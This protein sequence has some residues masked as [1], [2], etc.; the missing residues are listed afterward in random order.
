MRQALPYLFIALTAFCL[1]AFVS[2]LHPE[3]AR[4]WVIKI[5]VFNISPAARAEQY[6]QQMI[7]A[8]PTDEYWKTEALLRGQVF[9]GATPE[10]TLLALGQP[11]EHFDLEVPGYESVTI[12]IYL[13]EGSNRYTM[14]QFL[15][16]QLDV[17]Q[18]IAAPEVERYRNDPRRVQAPSKVILPVAAQSS[19]L[20]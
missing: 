10:M 12:M 4:R 18:Q 14:L 16:N 1:L 11:A 3:E 19:G 2:L 5:D 8:I 6:R 9:K 15:N 20:Q 7:R 13:F 17:S